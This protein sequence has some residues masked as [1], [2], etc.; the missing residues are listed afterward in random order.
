MEK[1]PVSFTVKFLFFF[2]DFSCLSRLFSFLF[3]SLSRFDGRFELAY[4]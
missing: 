1:F 4:C 3:S 2:R